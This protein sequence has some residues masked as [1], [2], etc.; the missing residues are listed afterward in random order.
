MAQTA[1]P[2]RVEL[3][4]GD[5]MTKEIFLRLYEQ[6]PDKFKA[7]LIGGVVFVASPLRA[8]HGDGHS[9]LD[10][11][12]GIYVI[13][14]PGT[15]H[16]NNCTTILAEDSVPQPDLNLR[17]LPEFG[18]R[19]RKNAEGY[20]EGPPELVS[21]VAHSSRA[22]DL[23][24]KRRDYEQHGVLEYVVEDLAD[25]C[26]HWFDLRSGEKL[27]IGSD[28]IIRSRAFPGL[29]IDTKAV[30]SEELAQAAATLERGL[31]SPEHAEFVARL[32]AARRA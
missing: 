27:S 32:A 14:T 9:I 1:P 23:H 19:S 10:T 11:I 25:H 5:R 21:E 2:G 26:F 8:D 24:A 3:Y 7:E 18:G 4:S 12:F 28:G 16:G 29:W 20:L 22:I 30:L 31:A 13:K 6:T 15:R 17:V